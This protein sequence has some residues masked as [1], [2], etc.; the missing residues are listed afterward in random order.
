MRPQ[1]ILD[2]SILATLWKQF[3]DGLFRKSLKM[4]KS[5][6]VFWPKAAFVDL[7]GELEQSQTFLSN[8]ASLLMEEQSNSPAKSPQSRAEAVGWLDVMVDPM[9]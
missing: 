6:L 1:E 9:D 7:C 3:G 5:R 2:N 8:M 4:W